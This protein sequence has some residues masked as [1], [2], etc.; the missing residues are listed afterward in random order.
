MEILAAIPLIGDILVPVLSFLIVLSVVVFVHEYGH[1]IVGR[2]CGIG[3]EVFSVGFGKRLFSW[4]DSRGTRWQVAAL[5]LGGYVKFVGDMD[6]ASAGSVDEEA[7]SGDERAR[8]FHLAPLWARALT[9]AAGPVANFILSVLIF[10]AL[11]MWVGRP[12]DTPVIAETPGAAAEIGFE[13]GD[14]VVS[15]GGEP[16]ESYLGIVSELNRSN[17]EPLEAV[18]IRDGERRQ[19]EVT[20][21]AGAQAGIVQP[22]MPAAQ[23]GMRAGDLVTAINGEPVASF[24]DLQRI[25]TELEPGEPVEVTVQREGE[26]F[27]YSFVP[28]MRERPHPETGEPTMLPT[29]GIGPAER[30]GLVP[31]T[32]WRGP[33]EA[34]GI[35]LARTWAIIDTTITFIGDMIFTNADTSGLGGPIGIAQISGERAL[36]GA[37]ELI[38]L[39]AIL[40]T[41]IG[42]LNLF[43]VPILDGGHLMFYA[44]EA[45]RGRPL[46]EGWM[47]VGNA[48]GLSLVLF[49]MVF[50]T[51]N[52]IGRFL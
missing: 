43:P 19:I 48:I 15:I 10:A 23:A 46:S 33:I 49:L 28:E 24:F 29:L 18:V 44:L 45:L 41:S 4:V 11:A 8:A 25:G 7:L 27:V 40:S 38:G 20:F 12:L 47:R 35:G 51:Y 14:R 9:V 31:E 34:L 6:P 16:V 3:A 5:P 39:I 37:E 22:G 32:G 21:Q 13:P 42:L 50:A 36:M 26:E 30:V 17:G 1:Y 2:W 52:D